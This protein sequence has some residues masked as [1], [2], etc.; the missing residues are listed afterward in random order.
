MAAEQ[1]N[2]GAL[3]VKS[4]WLR[5]LEKAREI[6]VRAKRDDPDGD[7]YRRY[8]TMRDGGSTLERCAVRLGKTPRALR[9]LI[10]RVL[11]R[12]GT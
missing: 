7:L 5:R 4:E 8:R 1:R 6:K 10:V 9:E 11:C 12:T 2:S 3:T